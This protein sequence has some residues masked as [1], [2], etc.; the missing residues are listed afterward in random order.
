MLLGFSLTLFSFAAL[1]GTFT[2]LSPLMEE[3]SGFNLGIALGS[4]LGGI[5]IS[6]GPGLKT[7]P[8]MSAALAVIAI[9]MA[10]ISLNREK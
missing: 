6:H 8:L 2:Y 7:I 10:V 4:T 1:F 5:L 3:I 9:V